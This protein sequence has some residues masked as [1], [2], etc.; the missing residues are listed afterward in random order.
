MLTYSV[1]TYVGTHVGIPSTSIG[2][3][4]CR[5]ISFYLPQLLTSI[6]PAR[7]IG[8]LVGWLVAWLGCKDNHSLDTETDRQLS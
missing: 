2:S 1:G 6:I 4:V 5:H 3:L 7:S 8:C